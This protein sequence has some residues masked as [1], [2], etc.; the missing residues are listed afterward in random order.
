MVIHHAPNRCGDCG[1]LRPFRRYHLPPCADA[2]K[3]CGEACDK[4]R[5]CAQASREK[6][7][8]TGQSSAGK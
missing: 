6:L 8:H 1:S 4:G 5:K 7:K 2:C 3:P